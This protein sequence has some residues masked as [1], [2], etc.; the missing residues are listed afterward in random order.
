MTPGGKRRDTRV[1]GVDL[2]REDWDTF[3]ALARLSG[4]TK[5]EYA[6]AR[7]MGREVRVVPNSRVQKLLRE[8]TQ[9][10]YLELRRLRSGGEVSPALE[11]TLDRLS[12]VFVGLGDEKAPTEREREQIAGLERGPLPE[13]GAGR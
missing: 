3:D 12:R 10:V 4:M 7:L 2:T 13:K 1:L 8:A 11:A 9:D 6:T 5:R